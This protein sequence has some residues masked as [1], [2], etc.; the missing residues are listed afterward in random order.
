MLQ[1]R[2]GIWVEARYDFT[3]PAHHYVKVDRDFLAHHVCSSQLL[4]SYLS[5]PLSVTRYRSSRP[6][7]VFNKILG[8]GQS[9]TVKLHHIRPTS[10]QLF[11]DESSKLART[12]Q[13]SSFTGPHRILRPRVIIVLL[14]HDLPRYTGI[15]KVLHLMN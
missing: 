10:H 15:S 11:A 13:A 8:S 6:T 7:R 2:T 14:L 9:Q 1:C 3:T 12:M 5:F 4:N